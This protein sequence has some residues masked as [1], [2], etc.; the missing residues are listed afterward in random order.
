MEN[1]NQFDIEKSGSTK[2]LNLLDIDF[3]IGL[4]KGS[5]GEI[6]LGRHQETLSIKRISTK[7]KMLVNELVT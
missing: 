1:S 2:I 6:G 5:K 3:E 7:S 4:S